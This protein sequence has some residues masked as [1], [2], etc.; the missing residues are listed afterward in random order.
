MEACFGASEKRALK[1]ALP[2]ELIRGAETERFHE[3]AG[4]SVRHFIAVPEK[5]NQRNVK[6]PR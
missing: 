5:I 1:R 2:E 3:D 4:C 6:L